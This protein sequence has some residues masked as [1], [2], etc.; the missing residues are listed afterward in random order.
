M[1][2]KHLFIAAGFALLAIGCGKVDFK[3]TKGGMPYK[4]YPS[5]QG[6]KI[7]EGKFV[8]AHVTQK[9]K[10]SVVFT[11]YNSLPVYFPFQANNNSYDIS[12]LFPLLKEGDSVYA[13]QVMDTFIKRNPEMMAQSPYKKDDKITTTLKILKVFDTQE[14]YQQDEEKERTALLTKEDADV[15]AYLSKNNITDAQ[16]TQEG[17][18][19]QVLEKGSGAPVEAGKY[20]T[21]M[22]RGQTFGGTVFDTNMDDS[23]GHTEPLGFMVGVGQMIK[24]FDDGVQLLNAGGKARI[25]IPSTLGY[26]PQPPSPD[27]KPFEHL[28]FDVEVLEVKAQAPPPP[29]PAQPNLPPVNQ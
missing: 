16:K 27:I 1:Q 15:K 24:G 28:I 23:K 5:K 21:V 11:T 26:G 25:Y 20:V 14:Q 10:D 6:A 3:K 7:T 13:V 17:T 18:Y 8:K 2:L 22:Y 19:V 12:E 4:L 9:I 29:N